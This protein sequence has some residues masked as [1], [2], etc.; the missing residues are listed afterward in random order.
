MKLERLTSSAL[1]PSLQR[2]QIEEDLS[3]LLGKDGK[4]LEQN[5]AS[6]T[7]AAQAMEE[8]RRSQYEE[9]VIGWQQKIFSRVERSLFILIITHSLIGLISMNSISMEKMIDQTLI[10]W[11]ENISRIFRR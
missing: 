8:T 7:D 1:I 9:M 2:L 5:K 3:R 10:H 4:Q 11:R 6:K